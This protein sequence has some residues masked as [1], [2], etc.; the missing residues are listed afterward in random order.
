MKGLGIDTLG[1]PEINKPWSPGNRW[2]HQMMMDIMFSNSKS[3]FSSAPAAHDCKSK[4]WGKW[5]ILAGNGAGRA[6][7]ADVD[8][9]WGRFVGKQYEGQGMKASY[10]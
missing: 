1:M 4:P 10:L 2:K 8:K 5:L 3:A 6:H 9:K 7:E